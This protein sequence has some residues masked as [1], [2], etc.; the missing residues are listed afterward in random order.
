M[1]R[2]LKRT[3]IGA[4]GATFL[5][6][7]GL[8]ACSHHRHSR[9]PMT[10]AE[11]TQLRERV[12][13][14]ATRALELDAT[15]QAKLGLLA[16]AIKVQRSA[17]MAGGERPRDTLQSLVAGPQFDRAKAQAFIEGKTGAVREQSPALIAAFG[18]FYDS[19]RPEQ[20][21]KLRDYMSRGGHGHRH[22]WR[23]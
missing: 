11:I 12:M 5:V 20:Q 19:L 3:L 23:G 22:F 13:D 18:D 8:A 9:A 15:Q 21:Q 17:L 10:D 14:K 2:W 4:L 7:G 16:D 6:G 1:R